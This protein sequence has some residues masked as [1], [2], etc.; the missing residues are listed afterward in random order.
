MVVL[1]FNTFINYAKLEF[2]LLAKATLDNV[3]K[4][5]MCL[6]CLVAFLYP[7]YRSGFSRD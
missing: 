2:S 7:F 6:S 3:K 5:G 1:S 4:S